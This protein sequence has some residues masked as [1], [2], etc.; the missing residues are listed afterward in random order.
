MKR[1]TKS[2]IG[3]YAVVFTLL[4]LA[5]ACDSPAN[6]GGGVTPPTP[7]VVD[8]ARY[9]AVTDGKTLSQVNSIVGF[10]GSKHEHMPN[11]YVW[12]DDNRTKSITAVFDDT[13]AAKFVNYTDNAAF[14]AVIKEN[15]FADP[16]KPRSVTSNHYNKVIKGYTLDLVNSETKFSGFKVKADTYI[17]IQSPDRYLT[18]SFNI[19]GA[20]GAAFFDARDTIKKRD[21]SFISE[22]GTVTEAKYDLITAGKTREELNTIMGFK[23]SKHNTL[24]NTYVWQGTGRIKSITVAFEFSG[25]A[26]YKIYSDTSV[27]PVPLKEAYLGTPV[28]SAARPVSRAKYDALSK[29]DSPAQVNTK[30]GFQGFQL[31]S[32][33][34]AWVQLSYKYI[35]VTFKNGSA[36]SASFRDLTASAGNQDKYKWMVSEDDYN[37]ITQGKTLAQIQE[38]IGS[39]GYHNSLSQDFDSYQWLENEKKGIAV[40]FDS[41]LRAKYA[42]YY[43]T[44]TDPKNL[45]EKYLGTP[46]NVSARDVSLTKY[47]GIQKGQK[48]SAVNTL[49]GFEGF[50]INGNSYMWL[51]SYNKFLIAAFDRNGAAKL[52]FFDKMSGT[53]REKTL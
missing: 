39:T 52:L 38:I 26:R 19:E 48:L 47:N 37:R 1:I 17:W 9:K 32:D 24:P 45:K 51:H 46:A 28:S 43:D 30:M 13:G 35:S 7:K 36:V 4:I 10:Q 22:E 16:G 50:R 2:I 23:S 34:Y 5:H 8:K 29:G 31:T 6:G 25:G 11:A 18:V 44:A 21:K 40:Y 15:Y 27:R 3:T 33:T 41:R 42:L 20:V 49:M 14:P 12:R 53:R